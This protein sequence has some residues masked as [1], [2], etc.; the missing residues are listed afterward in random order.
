MTRAASR[1]LVYYIQLDSSTDN[2]PAWGWSG[3][4]FMGHTLKIDPHGLYVE[5]VLYGEIDLLEVED[6]RQ[7]A[8]LVCE[9]KHIH[10]LLVD[11]RDTRSDLSALDLYSLASELTGRE[12]IPGMRY[13]LVVGR[14]SSQ[15]DLFEQIARRRGARLDHFTVYSEALCELKADGGT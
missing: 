10:R 11:A 2:N 8:N 5:L 6:A 4:Y 14:D 7:A 13:A 15:L 9:Q 1:I 12:S 3:S